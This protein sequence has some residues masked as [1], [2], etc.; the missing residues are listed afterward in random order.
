MI[1]EPTSPPPMEFDS[2]DEDLKEFWRETGKEIVKKS[3]DTLEEVAKQILVVAGILEGLYF[4]AITFTNLQGKVSGG[5]LAIYLAPIIL[6]LITLSISLSVF[7]P[8]TYQINIANWRVCKSTFEEISK[9]KLVAVRTA[10]IFLGL[11][12]V[13]LMVAVWVYLVI[14]VPSF[15]L[16]L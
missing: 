3:I 10:S 13:S 6:L 16:D 2:T 12:V 5:T 8:D 14:S 9:S 11:A 1:T 4:H 15:C 7:L